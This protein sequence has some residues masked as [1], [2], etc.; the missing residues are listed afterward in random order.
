MLGQGAACRGLKLIATEANGCPAFAA[1]KPDPESGTWL[2]WSLTLLEPDATDAGAPT[3]AGIHNFLQPFLAANLFSTF[4]LPER[5]T[6]PDP[7]VAWAG[8]P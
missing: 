4:G 7:A 1:Y 8:A 3:V 6:D 5:R 2:P